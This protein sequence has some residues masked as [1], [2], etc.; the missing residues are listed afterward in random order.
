MNTVPEGIAVFDRAL[1]KRNRTR[2]VA[3]FDDH[4]FLFEEVADR[5]ADRLF[6]VDRTFERALVVGGRG[7][8]PD[9]LVGP[10][11][12]IR[13]AITMDLVPGMATRGARS[14]PA[15]VG[16]EEF[17]PVAPGS[18]DLVFSALSLHWVNDLPGA[19]LQMRQ[20]LK[21]DG[22]LL[23]A[24][25]GGETLTELRQ[26]LMQA[27]MDVEDGVSP[28]VS[29]FTDI[30]DAGGLLQR[31]G[32]GLPVTDSDRIT[33]SYGTPFRLLQDLRGM[34]EQNTVLQRRKTFLRRE[35]LLRAMTL[36]GEMFGDADGRVPATF[37]I[38]QMTGWAPDASQQKPL[39][40][41]SAAHRLA[42][43]LG[44]DETKL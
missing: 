4:A 11:A 38:I 8:L 12:R 34:G 41:G 22:L 3:S 40:P 7:R 10:D 16:D 42:S 19:L 24:I 31:A 36:Y 23:V 37:Q 26:V 44:S 30:R 43:A 15:L 33:V 17:L 5:L 28:R 18:I 25:L 39:R 14:G 13:H 35:T 29:P 9:G 21:P 20:A 1:H 2:A 6:D 32:F 27:E